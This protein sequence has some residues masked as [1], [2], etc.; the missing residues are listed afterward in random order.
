MTHD[1]SKKNQ[2]KNVIQNSAIEKSRPKPDENISSAMR[3]GI[4]FQV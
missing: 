4:L 1:E 2:K 3:K